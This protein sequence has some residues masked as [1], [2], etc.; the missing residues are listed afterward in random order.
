MRKSLFFIL[1]ATAAMPAIAAGPGD[2]NRGED[3][4]AARAERSAAS[5]DRAARP[6][7]AERPQR[8]ENVQRVER[9]Q[10]V[11]N[12]Q[13]M[14][15][16][17][18]IERAPRAE[19][20]Q[21]P[22]DGQRM[23]RRADRASD[24]SYSGQ[25][26]DRRDR[27]G[28]TSGAVRTAPVIV[29]RDR[30]DSVRNWRGRDRRRDGTTTTVPPSSG[31]TSSPPYTSAHSDPNRDDRRW[32]SDWRHDDRYDWRNHRNHYSSLF[33]LGSYYDPY[34]YGYRRFSI[35]FSLWPSYYGSRYWLNDP[36]Q[37]RLPAVY[38]PY[39]WVRY[40]DDALLVDIYS[41]EVVDVIRDFFW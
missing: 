30:S 15:N 19:A 16:V 3:R 10:R 4:R 17:Q 31:T 20:G 35:G 26:P 40:Y 24:R 14:E 18:R 12:I 23:I 13:R 28:Y 37:Y 39:R 2:D 25:R 36:W 1:L 5:D 32:S 38:G 33:R 6:E 21:R 11:E 9:P 7:R 34:G 41:G 29:T 27:T 8:V 22:D